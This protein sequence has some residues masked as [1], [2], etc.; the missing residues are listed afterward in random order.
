MGMFMDSKSIPGK[1][2]LL[3]TT[4]LFLCS[5]IYGKE[6][7]LPLER[8]RKTDSRMLDLPV[9]KHDRGHYDY[10]FESQQ[11]IMVIRWNDSAVVTVAT[12]MHTV[13]PTAELERYSKVQHRFVSLPQ[14]NALEKCNKYMGEVD[15]ADNCVSNYTEPKL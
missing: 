15:L 7:F 1:A 9:K 14:P 12:N 13:L 6:A 5:F 8:S 11:E 4:R 10:R 3:Q 2:Q